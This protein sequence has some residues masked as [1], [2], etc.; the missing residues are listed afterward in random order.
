[1]MEA[2]CNWKFREKRREEPL[3][4]FST[5]N[6]IGFFSLQCRLVIAHFVKENNS[7]HPERCVFGVSNGFYSI[8]TENA[9]RTSQKLLQ[10]TVGCKKK[11]TLHMENYVELSKF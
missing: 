9:I 6:L 1:M 2:N 3:A 8:V 5:L 4:N 10:I 7:K 11:T